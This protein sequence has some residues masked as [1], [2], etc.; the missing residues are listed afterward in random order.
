MLKLLSGILF[1]AAGFLFGKYVENNY[2]DRYRLWQDIAAFIT[3]CES[4]VSF[5][6]RNEKEIIAL[7]RQKKERYSDIICDFLQYNTVKPPLGTKE[8]EF[9]TRLLSDMKSLD[10]ATLTNTLAARN[11]EAQKTVVE[12]KGEIVS[13]GKTYSK[14]IP[15]VFLGVF[16]LL[17]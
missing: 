5:Q 8:K 14:L 3:L 7:F 13:K 15:L 12:K 11:A 17:V 2:S 1:V 6:A 10:A 16:I 4:E 9:L